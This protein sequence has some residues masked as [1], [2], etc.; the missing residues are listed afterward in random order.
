MK[1]RHTRHFMNSWDGKNEDILVT[2]S[3]AVLD[4]DGILLGMGLLE[5]Y[6]NIFERNFEGFDHR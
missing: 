5:N 1:T 2:N 3:Q 6:P 4:N